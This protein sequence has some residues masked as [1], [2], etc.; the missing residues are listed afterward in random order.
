MRVTAT[1]VPHGPM[2]PSFAFRF[3]TDHGSVIF[4]DDTAKSENLI[5]LAQGTDILVHEAVGV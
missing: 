5:T 4:F 2:Y 1:L 3:D